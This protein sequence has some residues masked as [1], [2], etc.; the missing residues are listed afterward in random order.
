MFESG[1]G[2]DFSTYI[3][4]RTGTIYRVDLGKVYYLGASLAELLS[5]AVQREGRLTQVPDEIRCKLCA[6][7]FSAASSA[8]DG[9][10]V[11]D[12]YEL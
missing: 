11:V 12:A 8:V 7:V 3:G 1:P 5:P 10:E 4:G 2:G 9:E 6:H